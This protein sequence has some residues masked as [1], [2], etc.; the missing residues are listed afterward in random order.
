M[1]GFEAERDYPVS[2]LEALNRKCL[3][4]LKWGHWNLAISSINQ[5]KMGKFWDGDK[6]TQ[7]PNH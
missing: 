1:W 5:D 7:F 6:Y 3:L 2:L 4:Q